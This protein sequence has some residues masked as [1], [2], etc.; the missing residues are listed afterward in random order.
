MS[1]LVTALLAFFCMTFGLP[2]FGALRSIPLLTR[3]PTL[4]STQI[5]F[6]LAGD[7][8]SV[9]RNGGEAKRLASGEGSKTGPVFSPDGTRIAFTGNDNGN[10]DVYVIPATGGEP[11]RLTFHPGPDQ[12]LNWTPDG[13]R[14]LF[15]SPRYAYANLFAP[16][17]RQFF[18]V[19]VEGGP[20]TQLPLPMGEEASFSPDGKN[21]AYVPLERKNSYFKR[22]RGGRTT[23]IRVVRLSDS[24]IE[25][26]PRH[27]STDFNPLWL[28]N[29]IYFLSDRNGPVTLF[30][31]DLITRR[32]RQVIENHGMDIT[33][34][35]AGPGAVV[36]EQFGSLHLYDL[37]SGTTRDVAV[38]INSEFPELQPRSAHIGNAWRTARL[39]PAGD[40]VAFE[41]WGEIMTLDTCSVKFQNL[42]HSPGVMDRDPAWSPDAKTLAYFSDESGEYALHLRPADGSGPVEKIGLGNPPSFFY[43]PRWSP[44]GTKIA[45]TDKRQH[46]WYVDRAAKKRMKVA[47]DVGGDSDRVPVWSPDGQWLAYVKNLKNGLGAIFLYSLKTGRSTQITD[48][49]HDAATPAFDPEG[50]R[51]YFT[52]NATTMKSGTRGIYFSSLEREGMDQ[53]IQ[54]LSAETRNCAGLQV[55]G[56]GSLILLESNR[57]SMF[58]PPN[59]SISKLDIASGRST[60]FLAGITS[61]D[62]SA[63]G[64]KILFQKD[65]R[66]MIRVTDEPPKSG[67]G[68]LSTDTLEVRFEPR[69]AWRQMYSEVWRLVRDFFYDPGLHGLDLKATEARYAPYVE[70]LTSRADLGSLFSEM[71]G[72]L[73]VSHIKVSGGNVPKVNSAP[74]PIKSKPG[75][76]L[77]ADF[78]IENGRYRFSKIY[79][80]DPWNP[81]LKAPLAQPGV[82]VRAGDYLFAVNGRNLTAEDNLYQF[83]E[84]TA[85][86]PTVIRVGQLPTGAGAREIT[87]TPISDELTLRLQDW[88][89]GNRRRISEATHGRVGYVYVPHT[90]NFDSFNR[91]LDAQKDKKAFIIDGRFNAGGDLPSIFVDRLGHPPLL[92]SADREAPSAPYPPGVYGPKVL[93][94]NEYAGSGGD[95]L[96]LFFRRQGVGPVIGKRTWGGLTGAFHSTELMDGSEVE[97]PDIAFWGPGDNWEVENR[98]VGPDIEVEFDPERARKGEDP[99]LEE[100]IKTV[101]RLLKSKPFTMLKR[102]AYPNYHR[103]MK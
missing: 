56:N 5:V 81:A 40:R 80:G 3:T 50:K 14:V 83:F 38:T 78:T 101:L 20:E 79:V 77:G 100:A 47:E 23:P 29:K 13:K 73:T 72:E 22:Y 89:D 15:A 7:L 68:A 12:A 69:A 21:L 34:A 36:Y 43:T 8:W 87:V 6:S 58:D 90:L 9:P 85:D 70:G 2:V 61:A 32:V 99:Q 26:I 63:D 92:Y 65:G 102:P 67:E 59:F 94:I 18:T 30:V 11:K 52:A 76:L 88:T 53:R 45:Y 16:K 31:Y 64:E 60:P 1:R 42:T 71:L 48:A 62:I 49:M 39:S 97:V 17:F 86:Q 44:D 35:S 37:H 95:A 24:H 55:L 93:L 27:N 103:E 91:E 28:G 25:E 66:W 54:S 98:G 96:A 4:N 46:I 19:S 82:R 51:L 74:T 41:A 10:Q 75:G 84:G 57:A 33:S